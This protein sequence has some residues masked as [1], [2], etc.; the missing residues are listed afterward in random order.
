MS[1]RDEGPQRRRDDV[2]VGG[3]GRA[4]SRPTAGGAVILPRRPHAAGG[5]PR[6]KG[7]SRAARHGA[8]GAREPIR[9]RSAMSRAGHPSARPAPSRAPV[10]VSLSQC[11]RR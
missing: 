11:A 1:R 10:T 6:A 2:A 5:L 4:S 3:H 7:T 8:G 9:L